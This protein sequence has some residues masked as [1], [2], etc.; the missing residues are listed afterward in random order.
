MI[1][2]KGVRYMDHSEYIRYIP[3]SKYAML[4]VHGIVGTPAHFRGLYPVI[5][6]DWSVYNILLDGHGGTVM[7]FARSSMEKWRQQVELLLE[8][9]LK[10]H[11][12]VLIVAHSMGTLFA[13]QA[14][15]RHPD[16]IPGLF[17]LQIP[18]KPHLPLK[19]CLCS[20]QVAFG[21]I[22]PGSPAEAMANATALKMTP[23]LW[24]YLAW[25]PR[26]IELFQQIA[27]TKKLL[28]KLTV[29]TQS[30]PSQKDELVSLRAVKHLAGHPYIAN[31]LLP[32]SGHFAYDPE[33]L[34]LLQTHLSEMI[35][36]A[37]DP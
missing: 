9:L 12:K 22:K 34:K 3:G 23:K 13:I 33:D 5:P 31:T 27:Y 11:E 10:K 37:T 15:I 2:E 18:L 29:P 28:P 26:Y 21:R 32:H 8:D 7:D 1:K 20:L 17:L 35:K 14:A 24:Q 19:T 16:R 25:I 4:M 6:E 30:Y 36:S